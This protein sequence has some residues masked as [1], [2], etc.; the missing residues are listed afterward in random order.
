V[1]ALFEIGPSPQRISM[2]IQL[3]LQKQLGFGIPFFFGRALTGGVLHRVFG[4][5]R[6]VMPL[7]MPVQ[8]VVGRPIHVDAPVPNPTQEQ[9]D[10]L[11]ARYVEELRKIYDD[12]KE[13]FLAERSKALDRQGDRAKEVLRRGQFHLEKVESMV[14]D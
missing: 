3:W 1:P 2:R 12:W 8:S 11:H 7:R 9:I 5:N 6:G 13:P 4:M 10:E 14:I